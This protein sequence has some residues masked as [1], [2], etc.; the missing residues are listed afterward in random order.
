MSMILNPSKLVQNIVADSNDRL[1]FGSAQP[2]TLIFFSNK[3]LDSS[4]NLSLR[5]SILSYSGPYFLA[6]GLNTPYLSVFRPNME[7][8][9]PE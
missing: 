5:V 2:L 4:W 1:Q 3:I 7:K 8:Y 9:G 6:F